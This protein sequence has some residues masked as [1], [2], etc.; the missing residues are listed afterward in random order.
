MLLAYD[1]PVTETELSKAL[2]TPAA[3]VEPIVDRL[4]DGEL[5]KKTDG[6]K[7]YTDFIIFTEKDREDNLK[8]QLKTA[9]E[10]FDLFW[11]EIESALSDLRKKEF[12]KRQKEKAKKNLELHFCINILQRSI[13][14]VR[15]EIIDG[16]LPYSE[17]PYRKNGGRWFAIGN[18]YSGNVDITVNME[19]YFN[20]R[21]Y[22]ISGEYG[23]CS[24]DVFDLKSLELRGYDTLVGMYPGKYLREDYMKWLYEIF[25]DTENSCPADYIIESIP[26]MI[27][28]GILDKADEK[29]KLLL[30][31][32]EKSEYM[33]E[34][35]LAEN[36][37]VRISGN[38]HNIMEE[39]LEKGCV[40]L[41]KHL[42]S[43]PKWLQY[44][45]CADCIPMAVI[46]R[47]IEKGMFLEKSDSPFPAL[48]LEYEKSHS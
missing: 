36:Y 18:K 27:K 3:F 39:V 43:V 12:Y 21:K 4:I 31:V 33:E 23:I 17:Y 5:M 41:P 37:M 26:E 40:H 24:K 19:K 45:Y 30:P 13:I 29:V 14:N 15:D 11:K 46:C 32:V 34:K 35:K 2:G 8:K 7:V 44:V 42:T 6:G 48:I 22:E 10:H 47:A 38:I 25:S 16:A 20:M 9:E 28:L 1:K